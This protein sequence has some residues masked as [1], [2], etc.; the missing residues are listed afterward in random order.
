MC[1]ASGS[2]CW[3]AV[4]GEYSLR[5]GTRM[6][7]SRL[8]VGERWETASSM[9][10]DERGRAVGGVVARRGRPDLSPPCPSRECFSSIT[11]PLVLWEGKGVA[12][13]GGEDAPVGKGP[14]RTRPH[15]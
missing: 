2:S 1:Q 7:A 9:H 6:V 14:R 3:S 8:D 15:P 10:Q 5:G 4:C 11:V 12:V 13:R